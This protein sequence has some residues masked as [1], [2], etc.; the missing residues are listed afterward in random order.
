MYISI[1]LKEEDWEDVIRALLFK[2]FFNEG[3]IE[4]DKSASDEKI[5]YLKDENSDFRRIRN[6]IASEVNK[7]LEVERFLKE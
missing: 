2:K 3:V 5:K 4:F 6:R 1:R 7:S